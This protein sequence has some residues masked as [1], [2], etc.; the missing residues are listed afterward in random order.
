MDSFEGWL[1]V[2]MVTA[3]FGPFQR[4]IWERGL[5]LLLL[6]LFGKICYTK[7]QNVWEAVHL[8]R[9][10]PLGN[11][12]NLRDLGGYPAAGGRV[13]AWER[14]LRGDNP[15]GLSEKDIE[16]LVDR[17]ITTVIDLRSE[18]E[19]KR[20]PDQLAG[21]TDFRYFHAPMLGGE[22]MPNLE[23]DVG[24]GYFQVLDRKE[25][26]CRILRLI[27]EAPG[28]VLFHCTAGKDRTGMVAA[29]LLS[30]AGVSR[31]DILADYQ[32]SEIY[33]A[34]IIRR[35]RM[36]VPDLVPFAGMSK[37]KYM[38]ECLALLDEAYGSV[39]GYLRAVGLSELEMAALRA[40]VL[41]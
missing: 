41:T 14:L 1:P 12:N 17:D 2:F 23:R 5:P 20:K 11:M 24:R 29:L 27:A 30:L 37:S 8:L 28:G 6:V 35:I 3:L 40:K 13:T 38:A 7:I 16:W 15:T 19:T 4:M 31:E 9:H 26:A 34:E 10:I 39:S 21:E 33:L 32:V 22:R 18:E 25:S 36:S